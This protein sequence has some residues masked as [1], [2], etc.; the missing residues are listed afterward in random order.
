MRVANSRLLSCVYSGV[1]MGWLGLN[2]CSRL[3]FKLSY[4][5]LALLG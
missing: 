2:F 3:V 5:G 1:E 4:S